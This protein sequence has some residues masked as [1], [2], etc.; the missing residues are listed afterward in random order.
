MTSPR[1]LAA[2]FLVTGS[3]ATCGNYDGTYTTPLLQIDKGTLVDKAARYFEQV[4]GVGPSY[5]KGATVW[6]GSTQD[7]ARACTPIYLEPVEVCG[8]LSGRVV[9]VVNDSAQCI[10]DCVIL[11]ELGHLG[12][13]KALGHYDYS[14]THTEYFNTWVH[15]TC[16]RVSP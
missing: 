3:L 10:M 13:L 9:G 7:I 15:E 4:Y 5:I 6:E 16:E 14:H 12:F 2:L 11:H 1:K 8:C